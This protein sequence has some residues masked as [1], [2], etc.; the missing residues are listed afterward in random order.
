[1][2]DPTALDPDGGQRLDLFGATLT[3]KA[4]TSDTAGAYSLIDGVFQPG[5]FAPLPHTHRDEEESF[6]VLDG[7]FEFSVGTSRFRGSRGAFV[8]VPRG[9]RHGFVNA[10]DDAGRL[11]I[12]HSPG[13]EGF[14]LEFAELAASGPPEPQAI[15]ALMRAWRME[16]DGP[17]VSAP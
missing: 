15:A 11:L 9:L 8:L 12:I 2:S 10:G 1:M 5:G 7:E 17:S 6:Y 14:F 16:V 3:I 13:L 4:A